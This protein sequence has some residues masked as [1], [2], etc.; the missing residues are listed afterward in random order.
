MSRLKKMFSR[1]AI[2]AVPPSLG[3][4]DSQAGGASVSN[5]SR[6]SSYLHFDSELDSDM[7]KVLPVVQNEPLSRVSLNV[8]NN[9][10]VDVQQLGNYMAMSAT[11]D[12]EI[13]PVDEKKKLKSLSVGQQDPN[14]Q[15][16]VK[17]TSSSV[18]SSSLDE[19]GTASDSEG[20][21]SKPF[22]MDRVR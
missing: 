18:G 3:G 13:G 4:Q 11:D 12:L 5:S 21:P 2:A 10:T 16:S 15:G 22:T 6:G 14:D 17:L 9:N 1:R 20:S 7:D 8:Q 19:E